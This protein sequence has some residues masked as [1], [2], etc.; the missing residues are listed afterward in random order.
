MRTFLIVAAYA[1]G[2]ALASDLPASAGDN[3]ATSPAAANPTTA[4]TAGEWCGFEDKAGS[5]FRCGY[6]N[7]N[8]CKAAVGDSRDS[9]C[10]PDPKFVENSTN[11]QDRG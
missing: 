9:Y 5:A 3:A 2:I 8:Q 11:A 4:P 6:S 1:V 7:L 10:I